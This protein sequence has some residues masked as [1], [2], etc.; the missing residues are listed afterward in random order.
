MKVNGY[1][2]LR[3]N[4]NVLPVALLQYPFYSLGV[5]SYVKMG[6]LGFILG[7]EVTHAFVG[8]GQYYYLDGDDTT[9]W[10]EEGNT[11]FTTAKQCVTALY[12]KTEETTGLK[13]NP[14]RTF[15]ENFA[16]IRGL[17]TAFLVRNHII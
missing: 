11:N 12:N 6:T 5:P 15:S 3:D 17:E 16:D 8:P 2:N 14:L 13:V 1:H 9:W 7:H 10:S 4:S